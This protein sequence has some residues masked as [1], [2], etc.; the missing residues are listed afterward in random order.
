[1]EVWLEEVRDSYTAPT[2]LERQR[3]SERVVSLH[4]V[5]RVE[6]CGWGLSFLKLQDLFWSFNDTAA[7]A[8]LELVIYKLY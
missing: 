7:K 8:H 3:I 6:V 1:M 2:L 5:I 4:R